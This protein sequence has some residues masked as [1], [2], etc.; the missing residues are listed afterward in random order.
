MGNVRWPWD[1]P[2]VCPVVWSPAVGSHDTVTKE[3]LPD[4]A[5]VHVSID[6]NPKCPWHG[7]THV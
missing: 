2:C 7:R 1:P 6:F 5:T 4:L 3:W